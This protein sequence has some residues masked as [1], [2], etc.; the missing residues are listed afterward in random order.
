MGGKYGININTIT[1]RI[2][3]KKVEGELKDYKFFCF[4]GKVQCFKIDLDRFL[5]HRAN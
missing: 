3:Y 1:G 4:D 2:E 5:I